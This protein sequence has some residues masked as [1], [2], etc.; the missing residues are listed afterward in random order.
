MAWGR[1]S[2]WV[3]KMGLPSVYYYAFGVDRIAAVG[4]RT[5]VRLPPDTTILMG[6]GLKLPKGSAIGWLIADQLGLQV[7]DTLVV[8]LQGKNRQRHSLS[9][10]VGEVL[11]R[12]NEDR[13]K[14]SRIWVASND[15]NDSG[16]K[17]S[18]SNPTAADLDIYLL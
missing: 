14:N 7:G 16:L 1:L 11:R 13:E 18:N 12:N 4:K 8:R 10:T 2:G 5:G 9:I 3:T 15:V 6:P 17:F